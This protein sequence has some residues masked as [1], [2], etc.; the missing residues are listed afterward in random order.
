MSPNLH[1]NVKVVYTSL[2][3]QFLHPQMSPNLH[4][5]VKVIHT[6]LEV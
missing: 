5:N 3:V 1:V 4:V 2:E 6:S